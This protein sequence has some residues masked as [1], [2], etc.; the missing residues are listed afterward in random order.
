MAVASMGA[1]ARSSDV[2][3]AEMRK[4]IL[5]SSLGTMFE[6]YDF[7]LFGSLAGIIGK[8]FFSGFPDNTQY[9]FALL[10]FAAGFL[11]RP[12]G[13]MIFGPMGDLIGR[14][15]TFLITMFI[16]GLAT[17]AVGV[18]PGYN[19]I[20]IW[21]PVILIGLRLLQGLAIG[22]EYGGAAI[23]VAEHAEDDRRGARTGWIQ[24]TAAMGLVLSLIV[25]IL[26][27]LLSPGA[28]WKAQQA[29]YG[30][31]WGSWR[32]PFWASAILLVV[33]IWIRLSLNESPVFQKMKDDSKLS[34]APLGEAIGNWKGLSAIL[35]ALFGLMMGQAVTFYCGNFYVKTFLLKSA[36][37]DNWWVDVTLLIAVTASVPFYVF[38]GWLSDKIGR[39]PVILAGVLAAALGYFPLFGMI[40]QEANPS[41]QAAASKSPVTISANAGDCNLQFD[42]APRLDGKPKFTSPCDIAVTALA[43]KGIPYSRVDG[44]LGAA[45]IKIG[46]KAVDSYDGTAA[47]AKDKGAAFTKSL[48]ETLSGAGYPL[49]APIAGI[50]W[51]LVGLVWLLCMI[52]AITYG[53]IAAALVEMFPSRYRYSALSLPYHLGNGW[54]GGILPA[55]T[56]AMVAAT[57][58][59]YFGLWYPVVVAAIC[60]IVGLIFV[61]ERA[62]Q[63]IDALDN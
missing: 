6:W 39:K 32:W 27:Q 52:S 4:V 43:G 37:V 8:H 22:G 17:L 1:P 19:S 36:Q 44:P 24:T 56:F 54:F 41:L 30:S 59:P 48:A 9:I 21:A 33:S 46:D 10:A 55:L 16:M 7:Y 50:D 25:L 12:F 47:D 35:I 60:F 61:R 11:V 53:P 14:K 18:L 20:G 38:F 26:A 34:R 51:K 2:S 29:Y 63:P 45:Q 49:K 3:S 13:A 58:N 23:Y 42:P 28:D 62:G 57:G 31:E 15:F 5:G 40:A